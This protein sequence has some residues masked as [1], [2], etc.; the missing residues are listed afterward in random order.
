M[1]EFAKLWKVPVYAGVWYTNMFGL[2]MFAHEFEGMLTGLVKGV[3]NPFMG[4]QQWVRVDPN[5][6]VTRNVSVP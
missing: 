3:P 2:N 5:G 4:F 1:H 6:T